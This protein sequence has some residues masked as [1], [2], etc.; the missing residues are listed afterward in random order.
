MSSNLDARAVIHLSHFLDPHPRPLNARTAS[1]LIWAPSFAPKCHRKC[2]QKRR[3]KCCRE[4]RKIKNGA[5]KKRQTK[6]GARPPEYYKTLIKSINKIGAHYWGTIGAHY[7]ATIGAHNWGTN[8]GTQC[9]AHFGTGIW[10]Q[11]G[12]Q[13]WS[14]AVHASSGR[15]WGVQEMRGRLQRGR[16]DY[17]TYTK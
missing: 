12:A 7:W 17:N 14:D 16:P 5:H 15:G 11:I 13:L 10:E 8:W 2:R 3:Q 1:N 6:I 4:C 9:G